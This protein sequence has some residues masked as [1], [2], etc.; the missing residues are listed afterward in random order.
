MS[1]ESIFYMDHL[2][3]EILI[4]F[5]CRVIETQVEVCFWLQIS[6]PPFSYCSLPRQAVQ[7]A[8]GILVLT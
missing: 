7:W 5:Y 8:T 1:S 4:L 3:H 6:C 2:L